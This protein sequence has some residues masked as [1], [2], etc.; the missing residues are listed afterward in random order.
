MDRNYLNLKLK[1]IE[2]K[3]FSLSGHSFFMITSCCSCVD[4][5]EGV[6]II[7]YCCWPVGCI[8]YIYYCC[9]IGGS[10]LV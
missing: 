10:I 8:Y 9:Y 2:R 6:L 3:R 7:S 1:F 4:S 5:V